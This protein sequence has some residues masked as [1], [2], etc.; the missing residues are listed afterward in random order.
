MYRKW[1]DIL[2]ALFAL[3]PLGTARP[4]LFELLP[5]P[6]HFRHYV[7]DRRCPDERS[8]G[9]VPGLQEL[10]NCRLLGLKGFGEICRLAPKAPSV[11]SSGLPVPWPRSIPS[12]SPPSIKVMGRTSSATG[13]EG[14]LKT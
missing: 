10:L 1:I 4:N 14:V 3:F 7:F 8:G 11:S 2:S 6:L 13:S 9:F 5:C 12:G